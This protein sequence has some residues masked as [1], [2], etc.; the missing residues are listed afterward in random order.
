MKI[1]IELSEAEVKG[2]K[3]YLK[4]QQDSK[5][6]KKDIQIH[7]QNIVTGTINAPQEA[8]SVFIQEAI[9]P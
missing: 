4:E 6:T 5:V 1:T 7:C 8:S 2:L 3:A 9:N